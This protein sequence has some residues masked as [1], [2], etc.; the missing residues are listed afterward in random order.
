MYFSLTLFLYALLSFVACL[1]YWHLIAEEESHSPKFA[2]SA[3]FLCLSRSPLLP[4]ITLYQI[5]GL[6][7]AGLLLFYHLFRVVAFSTTT[8]DILKEENEV[9]FKHIASDL[10]SFWANMEARMFSEKEYREM[11]HFRGEV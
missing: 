8:H 3:L 9:T 7:L 4:F 2:P 10:M 5:L 6:A 11:F 1:N